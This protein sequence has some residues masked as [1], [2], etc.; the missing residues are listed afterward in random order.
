MVGAVR[1]VRSTRAFDVRNGFCRSSS[2]TR[3]AD[4]ARSVSAVMR[5][6]SRLNSLAIRIAASKA[7]LAVSVT[8]S[9]KNSSLPGAVFPHLLQ[10]AIVVAAMRLQ[11]EAEIE[12]RLA[13]NIINAVIERHQKTADAP[14]TIQKG[15]DGLELDEAR[16]GSP[17]RGSP[18][19]P[20]GAKPT[21]QAI[22]LPIG[23]G[24]ARLAARTARGFALRLKAAPR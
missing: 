20:R 10:Q 22:E 4:P 21:R 24:G 23:V 8:P 13:Q 6:R 5:S 12:K 2:W 7:W 9:R 19:R 16:R 17:R 14:V 3:R 1:P 15:M 11:I 18:I